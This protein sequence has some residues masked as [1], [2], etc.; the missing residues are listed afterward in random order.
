MTGADPRREPTAIRINAPRVEGTIP[1]EDIARRLAETSGQQAARTLATSTSSGAGGTSDETAA[2]LR[3][4]SQL[5]TEM[6]DE[7]AALPAGILP[8]LNG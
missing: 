3:R 6:A 1:L 8:E 4:L 7:L 5:A 2:R